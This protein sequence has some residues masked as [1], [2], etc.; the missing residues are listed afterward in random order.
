MVS[1]FQR[2][3]LGMVGDGVLAALVGFRCGNTLTLQTAFHRLR[4]RGAAGEAIKRPEKQNH[5]Q[6]DRNMNAALHSV[7]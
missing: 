1:S 5:D 2:R 7:P 3:K 4:L 6:A